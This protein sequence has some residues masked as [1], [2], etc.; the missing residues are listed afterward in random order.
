[1]H[2]L[3]VTL[4]LTIPAMG[5]VWLVHELWQRKSHI[6]TFTQNWEDY[7]QL[8]RPDKSAV[9]IHDYWQQQKKIIHE[10]QVLRRQLKIREAQVAATYNFRNL[11]EQHIQTTRDLI[12]VLMDGIRT[13]PT[14]YVVTVDGKD[15]DLSKSTQALCKIKDF[16]VSNSLDPNVVIDSTPEEDEILTAC[17]VNGSVDA[18]HR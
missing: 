14:E 6:D 3:V 10:W 12:D 7:S 9:S 2:I 8:A 4:I 11:E 15:I 5:V 1:M 13:L 18:H 16:A 17:P